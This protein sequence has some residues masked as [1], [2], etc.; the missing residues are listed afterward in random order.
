MIGFRSLFLTAT[1][2]TSL[3]GLALAKPIRAAALDAFAQTCFSPYLTAETAQTA[4]SPS[5]ARHDFYDLAP[6]SDVPPS[7]AAIEVTPGTDR[8][9]EVALDGEHGQAA[10]DIA[11]A[12]LTAEGITRDTPLPAT[13]TDA[14]LPGTTLLA[15]RF[16]NPTRI[17]VVHTGTRPGPHG[18]ETFLT[19]ERLTPEASREAI[20]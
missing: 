17:A 1:L 15:A 8:R 2:V 6:F 7:P 4:I 14:K 5:G 10:A 3:P 19:V 12:A 9:C 13:H 16:L 18:P 20:Q 11:K